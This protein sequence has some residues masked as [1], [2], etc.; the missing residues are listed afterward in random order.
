MNEYS[1]SQLITPTPTTNE[2]KVINEVSEVRLDDEL[3]ALC[4]DKEYPLSDLARFAQQIQLTGSP[5]K[6]CPDTGE[7]YKVLNYYVG[8]ILV[9]NIR[10]LECW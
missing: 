3:E 7:L 1:E 5:G 4:Q 2:P 6:L 10:L 9:I 8:I